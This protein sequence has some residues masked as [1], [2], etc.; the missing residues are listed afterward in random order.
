MAGMFAGGLGKAWGD[1]G[2]GLGAL[3]TGGTANRLKIMYR[4]PFQSAP[5]YL[6]AASQTCEPSIH[7]KYSPSR[8]Y[9]IPFTMNPT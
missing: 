4:S 9:R 3:G 2:D 7:P 6:P 5:R 1:D 8:E